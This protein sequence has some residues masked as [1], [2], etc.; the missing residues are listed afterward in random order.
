MRISLTAADRLSLLFLALL[1]VIACVFVPASHSRN[2]LLCTYSLL[3]GALVALARL[4]F[5]RPRA[6]A[7]FYLHIAFTV[8]MILV[9]FNSLGGL[10]PHV[11]SRTYDQLLIRVDYALFGVHPTVWMER[12]VTPALTAALQFAYVSYY[13]IPVSLGVTLIARHRRVEFEHAL[14]GIVLCFYLSYIGYL[15]VPAV[16]PRFTLDKLQTAGLQAGRMIAA[17]QD[18]LNRL[19]QNKTDAFPS[20]HTAIALVSLYYAGRSGERVLFAILAPAV[21]AL[22]VSTVYLRYH[23]VIDV[24]AGIALAAGAIALARPLRLRLSRAPGD[25][26]NQ[27]HDAA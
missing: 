24:I 25:A 9:L 19:E 15:L 21:L 18:I 7:F 13:F 17:I 3:A 26:G 22:I 2:H 11:R 20:G 14:F 16:G 5:G 4:R 12:L 27:Q 8:A 1:G 6:N 10:I 23:Y